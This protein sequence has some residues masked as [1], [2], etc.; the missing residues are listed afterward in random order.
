MEMVLSSNSNDFN[1][2]VLFFFLLPSTCDGQCFGFNS[3]AICSRYCGILSV[4]VLKTEL[5]S[6]AV[7]RLWAAAVAGG[8]AGSAGGE[9]TKGAESLQ[10]RPGQE[11]STFLRQKFCKYDLISSD[12]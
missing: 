11:I 1:G 3:K 5:S 8:G 2:N 12:F 10:P 4:L 6:R 9:R 7:R